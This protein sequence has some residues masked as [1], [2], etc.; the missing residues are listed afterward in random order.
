MLRT[1]QE[2]IVGAQHTLAQHISAH[3]VVFSLSS[4]I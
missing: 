3:R 1:A 4:D 2:H